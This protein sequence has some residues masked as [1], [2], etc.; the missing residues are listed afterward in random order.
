MQ[1]FM[2]EKLGFY[3]QII[4]ENFAYH[5]LTGDS[6]CIFV[7]RDL[8]KPNL[9]KNCLTLLSESY[10]CSLATQVQW[11]VE[12]LSRLALQSSL[13]FITQCSSQDA[14]NN[15]QPPNSNSSYYYQ[16]HCLGHFQSLWQREKALGRMTFR[17][18]FS[19]QKQC[20]SFQ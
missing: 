17:T 2:Q 13:Y 6:Q 15:L 18:K 10:F 20:M 19:A 11:K 7:F 16:Q 8:E 5:L 14:Y 3:G 12:W 9:K 1:I 4:L